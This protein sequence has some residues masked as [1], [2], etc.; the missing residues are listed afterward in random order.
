MKNKNLRFRLAYLLIF[1][2]IPDDDDDCDDD[3]CD[4][5]DCDD[6]D[7]NIFFLTFQDIDQCSVP[8]PL[9]WR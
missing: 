9:I 4:D 6:D 5:N 1:F 3:D 7:G 2:A 8:L